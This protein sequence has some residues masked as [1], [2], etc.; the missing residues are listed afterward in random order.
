M[1]TA[2]APVVSNEQAAELIARGL[3]GGAVGAV[4]GAGNE[5][6][7]GGSLMRGLKVGGIVG[8]A[9]GVLSGLI[10]DPRVK[11]AALSSLMAAVAVV[12]VQKLIKKPKK[13]A[14]Y[15]VLPGCH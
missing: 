6:A 14:K 12:G 10:R 9:M 5:V 2:D 13:S 4:S 11:L 1:S 7:R 15:G 8:G 3:I